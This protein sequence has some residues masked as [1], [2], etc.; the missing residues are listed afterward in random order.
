M[1]NTAPRPAQKP[2][3]LALQGGGAHGAFTWGV[4]D[5]ILEDGRLHIEAISGASAGAMNAVVLADGLLDGGPE[6]ARRQLE[7]FWR[8]ASLD[9]GLPAPARSVFDTFLSAW[10][11]RPGETNP[12]FDLFTANTSPY[13]FNPLNI[14][15][16]KAILEEEINFARLRARAP[17]RLHIAAT[18]VETGKPR[19]FRDGELTAAHV[20]ASACLPLIFRAVEIDG[21]AY[22][23][24]GYLGNPPLYP[25]FEGGGRDLLLVQI[26]PIRR[27]GT[28]RSAIEIQNRLNEIS[29]NAPLLHELRAI[30]FVAR[31]IDTGVLTDPRYKR[32]LMHRIA[33]SETIDETA[34]SKSSADFRFFEKLR[35]AGRKA[36]KAWLKKNFDAI[37]EN[38]TMD[39]RQEFG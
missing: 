38:E 29:F 28:P 16:L 33:M 4:L 34:A 18:N 19:V 1:Q 9:G 25:L 15:P 12:W 20:A 32:I 39:L 30:E 2:I 11:V 24:G 21:I 35:D 17:L 37:G 27:K 3:K 23:D 6:K 10:G 31:L 5:A 26:N 13:D 14:N 22:W 36:A 8:K 7:R